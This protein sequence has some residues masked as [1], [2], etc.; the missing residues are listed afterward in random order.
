[1]SSP[2]VERSRVREPQPSPKAR[3]G[4]KKKIVAGVVGVVLGVG[5]LLWGRLSPFARGPVLQDMAEASDSVVTIRSFHATHFPFPGCVI[6]GLV[7][8]HGSDKNPPL[9]TI[10]RVIVRGS[11]LGMLTHHV[12]RITAVGMRIT[13]APFG[14]NEPIH[15]HPSKVVVDE[16]V[17]DGAVLE[18]ESRDPQKAALRFD[19]HEASLRNVGWSGPLEYKVKVHNP[20]PPGEVEAAGE[21]GVWHRGSADDTPISG[22]YTFDHADLGVYHGIA[23]TLS[24][25]GR[26]SGVLKHIDIAGS[27][28]IPDFEV[29]SSG[30][31][32]QLLTEFTGYV[33]AR[34]GDTYLK[35]VDSH[36]RKTHVVAEGSIAGT[37]G[38]KGKTALI[39]LMSQRG[40]IEDILGLFVKEP[41]APMSGPVSLQAQVEI[42]PGNAPFLKKVKLKGG[43]G[44]D[45]ASFTKP[46]TQTNV[47]KL[48]A[49][50]QGENKDDPA[51]VLSDLK[52]R[53]VLE[54]GTASF[55][56][57]S[58]TLPGAGARM[59]G[60]YNL[61]D[62]KVDLNGT[63]QVESKISNTT[64]GMKALLLKMMDPF[65]KK[66]K[67][68]E[69]VPVHIGG[70]YEH[71][72][73]GLDLGKQGLAQRPAQPSGLNAAE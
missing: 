29:R 13:V 67:K 42:P 34:H 38:R 32:V 36:F 5:I 28:D 43:F 55:S 72:Q 10:D 60:T 57:L 24:S 2:V 41:R 46:E 20:E 8:R 47:N 48:S 30:H 70:T 49:G 19:I 31:P 39:Q 6:E 14:S 18:F 61:I 1:M 22:D 40:R 15:T 45:D 25:K 62:H 54:G 33:N 73:F 69:I 16:I 71:P 27:I 11:Y 17:A 7:F 4:H 64:S 35:R 58:F 59:H 51:N 65:F 56:D 12:P 9:I 44:I 37:P 63:M 21:F 66:K 68:G 26:F 3:F 52:G 23:G 50:A 53:L